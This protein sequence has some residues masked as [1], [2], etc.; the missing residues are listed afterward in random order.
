MA[1]QP[2]NFTNLQIELALDKALNKAL[3]EWITKPDTTPRSV[4]GELAKILAPIQGLLD[5]ISPEIP[6]DYILCEMGQSRLTVGDLRAVE[7]FFVQNYFT[8]NLPV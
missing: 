4:Y 7:D 6:E 5:S 2:F 3:G 8:Q 1:Y